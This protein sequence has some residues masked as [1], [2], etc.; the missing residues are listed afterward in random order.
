MRDGH[1]RCDKL[2]KAEICIFVEEQ[3]GEG[4]VRHLHTHVPRHR[5]SSD[6]RYNLLRTLVL[7]F[8]DAD[9]ETIVRSYL[10]RR[11]TDPAAALVFRIEVS[12]PEPGVIRHFCGRGTSVH[13]WT[14]EVI[15]PEK[16]RQT[17]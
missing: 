13:A 2:A 16:F 6:A 1:D 10:N 7:R 5:L 17:R 15:A 8:A 3:A 11:G 9:A 14:D 4:F 12:Y